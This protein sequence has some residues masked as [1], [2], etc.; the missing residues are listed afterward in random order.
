MSTL[1]KSHYQLEITQ[2]PKE[3]LSSQNS[4]SN[5]E[6]FLFLKLPDLNSILYLGGSSPDSFSWYLFDINNSPG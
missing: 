1:E 4:P 5:S 6:G 3:N 2:Y